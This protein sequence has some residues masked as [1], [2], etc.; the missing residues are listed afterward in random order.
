MTTPRGIIWAVGI[1]ATGVSVIASAGSSPAAV[2]LP[3]VAWVAITS[4]LGIL[5][6]ILGWSLRMIYSQ[7]TATLHELQR[8]VKQHGQAIAMLKERTR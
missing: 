8:E 4:L 2:V 5:V 6:V 1:I 3:G 7:V